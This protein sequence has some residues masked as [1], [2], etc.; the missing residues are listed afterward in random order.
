MTTQLCRTR[1]ALAE[2][3]DPL[4]RLAS[5]QGTIGLVP[6]MGNLHQGHLRLVQES[7]RANATTVVSIF[8]NPLQFG[9]NEDFASYPRTLAADLELIGSADT[10]TVVF[11]PDDADIYPHGRDRSTRVS[12]PELGSVLCGAHRPGHFDGV[13]TVVLKLL[14]I[15]R[16]TRAYFGE[17]DY[18]QLTIIRRM[19]SDLDVATAIVGVPTVR[20]ADGLALSS[21]NQYL[22]TQERAIAPV[23]AQTLRGVADALAHGNRDFERLEREA[24]SKLDGAGFR[25]DYITIAHPDTLQP[26]HRDDEG[27]VVLAAARLGKA[28]LID[29][30]RCDRGA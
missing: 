12:V 3:L 15:V 11:A 22:S 26:A 6:T 7:M 30:V 20:A 4:R 2:R 8:V 5:P 13:T 1:V 29:N 10:G 28:R 24:H 16:P 9:P 18:Q 23:L 27:F 17:K 14:N 19:V 21:R 25:T